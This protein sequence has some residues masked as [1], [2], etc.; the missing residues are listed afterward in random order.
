ME[1]L[2]AR[3]LLSASQR[4]G[5]RVLLVRRPGWEQPDGTRTALLA[6]TDAS[7][8]WIEC[9]G[10]DDPAELLD[11]DLTVLESGTP[12]GVGEPGPAMVS[13]V[14]TNG[15]HDACCADRGRP[16]V[17]ALD[18]AGVADVWESTHVGGDRFAANVVCLPMG[19]YLGRVEPED[20]EAVLAQVR[21]GLIPLENYRGRSCFQPLV[22][23][24]EWH[25]RQELGERRLDALR[26]TSDERL[27]ED[28][29]RVS[30]EVD[31][32]QVVT[33]H[34]RRTRAE[35]V[36]QL[37]CAAGNTGRPWRYDLVSLRRFVHR[38]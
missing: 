20:A 37:T 25:V 32:G 29:R 34:V 30:F 10:F 12:P 14:C 35:G 11:L 7:G 26:L 33:A 3:T 18:E 31:G 8:G 22:Q 21:D 6:R 36:Q 9:V 28:E 23:A 27:A 16:V 19:L 1:D 24:A 5:F 2:V 38:G 15:R 17:R 13:L 4:L